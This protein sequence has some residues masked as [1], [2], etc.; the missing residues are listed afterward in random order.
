[1][2]PSNIT[3]R[4]GIAYWVNATSSDMS[5][6]SKT[7]P[8][9]ELVT[10]ASMMSSESLALSGDYFYFAAGP[11]AYRARLDGSAPPQPIVT[12]YQR[13][14]TLVT[15]DTWLYFSDYYLGSIGRVAK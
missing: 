2:Q 4:N 13:L 14:G 15:D 3:L 10:L 11:A 12:G 6:V 8:N 1:M 5:V 9:G 7:L